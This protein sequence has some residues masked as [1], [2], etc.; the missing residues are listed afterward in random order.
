MSRCVRFS[1][2]GP[3][4]TPTV[5]YLCFRGGPPPLPDAGCG[6]CGRTI[7]L[8]GG[9]FIPHDLAGPRQPTQGSSKRCP[10]VGKTPAQAAA[11]GRLT[12]SLLDAEP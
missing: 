4:G 5:G 7:S 10:G 8:R 2:T 3:D 11:L 6:G 12:P 9:R 1:S